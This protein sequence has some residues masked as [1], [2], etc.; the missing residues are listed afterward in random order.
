M[1]WCRGGAAPGQSG[2]EQIRAQRRLM[3]CA[4]WEC[5]QRGGS[6]TDMMCS[7][8]TNCQSHRDQQPSLLHCTA[9]R[10][11]LITQ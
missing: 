8:F 9:A 4:Q 7:A 1:D 10:A 3:P 6:C 5:S 2:A 11:R